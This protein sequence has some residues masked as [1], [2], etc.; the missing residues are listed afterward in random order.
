MSKKYNQVYNQKKLVKDYQT[1][2]SNLMNQK[3]NYNNY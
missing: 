1:F 3:K 2:K